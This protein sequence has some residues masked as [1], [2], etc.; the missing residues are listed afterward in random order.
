VRPDMCAPPCAPPILNFYRNRSFE[1][2]YDFFPFDV[3]N[4]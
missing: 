3:I 1:I 2:I 4:L